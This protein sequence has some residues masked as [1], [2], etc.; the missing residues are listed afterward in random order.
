MLPA[1]LPPAKVTSS[2]SLV[3]LHQTRIHVLSCA[4]AG[5]QACIINLS[6]LITAS[7]K[8]VKLAVT[9]ISGMSNCGVS[10]TSLWILMKFQG[11]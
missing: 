1:N 3:H 9:L 11:T 6:K 2:F 4:P 5:Q 10:S 8:T 7:S